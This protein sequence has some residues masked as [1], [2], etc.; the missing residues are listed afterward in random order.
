[1]WPR[2][3][4]QPAPQ[5]SCYHSCAAPGPLQ[6]STLKGSSWV[7]DFD[8]QWASNPRFVAFDFR[9]PEQLPEQ[10]LGSC[11]MVVIDPPFITHDVW[12]KYAVTARLLLRPGGVCLSL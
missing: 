1:M 4:P 10:L 12:R 2:A 5:P 6:D 3:H 9:Q 7:L 8:Q 11:A